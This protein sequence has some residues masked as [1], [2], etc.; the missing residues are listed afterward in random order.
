[1]SDMGNEALK[2]LHEIRDSLNEIKAIL[3]GPPKVN[4][5]DRSVTLTDIEEKC[6][7]LK[8]PVCSSPMKVRKN[9][10]TDEY[11]FGCTQYPDCRGLREITGK[12]GKTTRQLKQ[13]AEKSKK[14]T[15]PEREEDDVPF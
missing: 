1:M 13:E 3:R 9:R 2:A 12:E 8:C 14:V 4:A 15:Q 11:F 10:T 7:T 5:T 6:K